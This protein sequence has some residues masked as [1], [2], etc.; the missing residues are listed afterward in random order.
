[1]MEMEIEKCRM[2][3]ADDEVSRL[4]DFQVALA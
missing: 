3:E 1:M 2:V 4:S